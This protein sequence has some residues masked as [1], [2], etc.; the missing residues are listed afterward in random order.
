MVDRIHPSQVPSYRN[1]ALPIAGI[2]III[3]REV[4]LQGISWE[5]FY[6]VSQVEFVAIQVKIR[7]FLKA[8]IGIIAVSGKIEYRNN[9]YGD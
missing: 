1:R 7:E 3:I 9:Q 5:R 8:A 2:E 6:Q 4:R